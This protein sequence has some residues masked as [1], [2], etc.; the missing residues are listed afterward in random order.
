VDHSYAHLVHALPPG[1]ALV[2]CHDL[3]AFRCLLEPEKEKRSRWFRGLTRHVLKGLQKASYIACVTGAVRE[4]ARA[5]GVFPEDKISVIP[6]GVHPAFT[7]LADE[8]SDDEA[9]RL[10]GVPAGEQIELLH[11]GTTAPRKRIDVLLRVVARIRKERDVHLVRVGGPLNET[12]QR[13]ASELGL[14]DSIRQLPYLDH[15]VLAAVYRRAALLLLTSES[16]GFGLPPVEAMACGCAVLVSDLP[17]LR[18]VCGDAAEYIAV[19]DVPAWSSKACGL[20]S[21][22]F[23]APNAWEHRRQHGIARSRLFQWPEVARQTLTLYR[24]IAEGHPSGRAGSRA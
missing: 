15:K 16:E 13:L 20:L 4:E 17:V 12:Q 21:E 5:M 6:N 8:S 19:G 10:I 18:E 24:Q 9:A 3:G 7:P 23:T 22:R 2:T 14:T 11:V 1:R